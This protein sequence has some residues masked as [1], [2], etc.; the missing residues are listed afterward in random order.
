MKQTQ[1]LL[2]LLI[3]GMLAACSSISEGEK[4]VHQAI[5]AHGGA[6]YLESQIEF[7]FRDIHYTIF[8]STDRFEYVREFSDSLSQLKDVLNNEGFT[9]YRNGVAIDTLSEESIG[10]Y[11]RSVNSVAYF[12]YL[13]YGLNDAAAIKEYLGETE[14]EGETYHLVKVTFTQEGGGDDYDDEFLYWIGKDDF[15]VD[16]LAYSYHTDGGGVR[17]RKVSD[18]IVVG[19][20]RFQNYLN[21]KSSLEDV[22]VDEMQALFEAGELELLSEI[23]LDNIEVSQVSKTK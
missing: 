11:S 15:Y 7:D 6:K 16:Y 5:E 19:G 20:I 17:M 23:I 13:P 22:S 18:V 2:A 4:V 9:R 14:L 3:G 1:L 8:K 10:K 12:A 21:Y